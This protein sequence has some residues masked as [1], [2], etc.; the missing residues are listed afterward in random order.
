VAALG[1]ADLMTVIAMSCTEIDRIHVLSD[2]AAGRITTNGG[3]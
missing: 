1:S 2:L 3:C